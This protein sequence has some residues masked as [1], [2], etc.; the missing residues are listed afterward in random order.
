MEDFFKHVQITEGG[1]WSWAGPTCAEGRYGRVP[2]V[3]RL[4]M[5]HRMAFLML[6]GVPSS[7]QVICHSCD[8][9]LCVNPAHLFAGSMK[10]NVDDMVAKGRA[11]GIFTADQRQAGEANAHAKLTRERALKIRQYHAETK[12]SYKELAAAFGLRSKGHAHAIA[13]GRLW[14]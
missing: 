2:K 6:V 4:V 7:G 14:P 1:C 3:P 5:A 12:C 13:I 11:H 9:G 10:D 8:N